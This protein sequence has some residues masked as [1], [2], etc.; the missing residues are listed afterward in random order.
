MMRRA[1]LWAGV[2]AATVVAVVAAVVWF[3]SGAS[4]DEPQ[5]GF[6]GGSVPVLNADVS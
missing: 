5:R 4:V 1:V 3:S 6:A 2:A